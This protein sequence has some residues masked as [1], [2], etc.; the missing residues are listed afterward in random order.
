M[1]KSNSSVEVD[2]QTNWCA[3]TIAF[4]HIKNGRRY[5]SY[6][7]SLSKQHCSLRLYYNVI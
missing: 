4:S 6:A 2:I 3:T 5:I 7:D 1:K